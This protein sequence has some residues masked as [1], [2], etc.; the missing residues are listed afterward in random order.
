M[1]D[2]EQSGICLVWLLL[3]ISMAEERITHIGMADGTLAPEIKNA[4]CRSSAAFRFCLFRA[5]CG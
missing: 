2:D 5:F 3:V 1:P 4:Q